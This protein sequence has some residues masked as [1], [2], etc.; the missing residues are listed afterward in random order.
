MPLGFSFLRHVSL[1]TLPQVFT[2]LVSSN[3]WFSAR[4]D[5]VPPSP[6]EHLAVSGDILVATLT[7]DGLKR[8]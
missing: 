7:D 4:G 2:T 6:P 1:L 8:W 5:F 3:Q